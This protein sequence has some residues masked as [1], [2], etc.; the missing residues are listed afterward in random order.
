MIARAPPPLKETMTNPQLFVEVF[1]IRAE[2]LP[3]LHAYRLIMSGD[4]LAQ[5]NARRIGSRLPGY[6]RQAFS[7]YWAW[8][9]G[10][11]VVDAAA[12]PEKLAAFVVDL[13]AAFPRQFAPLAA[14]EV[15]VGWQPAPLQS[16][17]WLVRGPLTAL[18]PTILEAL[19]RTVFSI[20]NTRVT[21]EYR[22]R[23]WSV[24]G[25][26]AL[27]VSVVSR[28]LYEPDLQ[29][30]AAT[31]ADATEMIGLWVADKQTGLQGEIVRLVGLLGEQRSRLRALTSSAA[32]QEIIDAAPDDHWVVRVASG[33]R[34]F[35]Y[36]TDALDLVIRPDDIAQFAINKGQMDRALH[37]KPA[38][39]AQM[40]KLVSDVVKESGLIA[41]AYHSNGAAHLFSTLSPQFS[42]QW[43]DSRP[44]PYLRERLAGDFTAYGAAL[45]PEKLHHQP[46]RLAVIDATSTGAKDF[47]EALRRAAERDATLRIEIVRVR[48]M[49][50]ISQ[51]N[52]DSAVRLL[53]KEDAAVIL[54]CLPDETEAAEEEAVNQRYV[55]LQTIGRALPSLVIHESAMQDPAQ[56]PHLLMGLLARAGG[57]PYLLADPLSYADWVVGLSLFEQQ[58]REG[59]AITG[60]S[61]VYQSNGHLRYHTVAGD[62]NATGQGIPDDLLARL[63]PAAQLGKQ[64]VLLHIDGRLS[65][66]A[67][68]ALGRREDALDATFLTVEL[69]RAGVPRLYAL[70]GGRIGPPAWG[71]LFRISEAEAFVQTADTSVQP[72][73][74]RAEAP[75]KIEQAVESILAFTILHYGMVA[76]SKLPVTIHQTESIEAGIARG[77]F[78]AKL[79]GETAFWL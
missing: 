30:Y 24:G 29:G 58:K 31:L 14:I 27:S 76:P 35:D 77:I 7:G 57:A 2:A 72:L 53:A 49:R 9:G 63:L 22:M 45:M 71:S 18:E 73:H 39:H 78:P 41:N 38:A 56:M 69:I 50:V 46:I 51:A 17:D 25:S 59:S 79:G 6:L 36:V 19:A 60:I 75:L 13:R 54:A 47:L 8:I 12:P 48:D 21:R 44:R 52:L 66:E 20:K 65:R 74:V 40:V 32:M 61:R 33:I 37:L 10:R 15:D 42:L 64:R 1:P 4:E 26:P 34:D 67:A 16:A 5:Q 11:L 28:L 62:F 43:G 23:T 55:R 3:P 68:Q 70:D